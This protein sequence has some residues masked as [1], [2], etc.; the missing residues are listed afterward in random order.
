MDT[1]YTNL[2]NANILKSN[3]NTITSLSNVQTT[4]ENSN[5][6][7]TNDTSKTDSIEISEKDANKVN[8]KKALDAFGEASSELTDSHD[9]AVRL[10][11]EFS[12]I[13][14]MMTDQGYNVP[15]F[16]LDDNTNS[17][18]FLSFLDKM[19]DFVKNNDII[20]NGAPMDKSEFYD[21]CDLYKEKLV[22]YGCN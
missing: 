4:K 12:V 7:S 20:H 16:N 10:R 6:T 13:G 22:Q 11:V 3:S 19:K 21:F 15:S 9:A 18:G 2:A 14:Q 17:T 5:N 8:K 1:I